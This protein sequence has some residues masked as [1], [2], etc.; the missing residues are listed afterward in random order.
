MNKQMIRKSSNKRKQTEIG[1][2]KFA[3]DQIKTKV[4][5]TY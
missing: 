1:L 3:K 5:R 2:N 4:N